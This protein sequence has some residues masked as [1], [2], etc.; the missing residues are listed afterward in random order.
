MA[1]RLFGLSLF[2]IGLALA[3]VAIVTNLR[4]LITE[5]GRIEPW[6]I[7][8]VWSSEAAAFVCFVEYG[9]RQLLPVSIT[10]SQTSR[11][12]MKAFV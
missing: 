8:I 7:P 9:V 2:T 3:G 10:P 1:A 11:L 4:W 12:T 6:K 5:N